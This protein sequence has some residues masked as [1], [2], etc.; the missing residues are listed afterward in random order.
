[1]KPM[2]A[3]EFLRDKGISTKYIKGIQMPTS[4]GVKHFSIIH[5]MEQ[6]ARETAIEFTK[7][8]LVKTHNKSVGFYRIEDYMKKW[9]DTTIIRFAGSQ[10]DDIDLD[11]MYD[12][13][14]GKWI[15]HKEG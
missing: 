4:T 10:R 12:D 8:V 15:E 1:M 7:I 13:V 5:L 11:E 2:N 3:E 9:M 14:K 6:Y